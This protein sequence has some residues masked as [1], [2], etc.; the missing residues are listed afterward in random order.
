MTRDPRR[1]DQNTQ[2]H[3]GHVY[4]ENDQV[5]TE[6]RTTA[7]GEIRNIVFQVRQGL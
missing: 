1:E 2:R 7:L 5:S 6:E 3:W 4:T